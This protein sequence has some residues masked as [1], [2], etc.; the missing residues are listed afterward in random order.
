MVENSL[1][2]KLAGNEGAFDVSLVLA[3][4]SCMAYSVFSAS[5]AFVDQGNH[6]VPL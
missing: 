2:M 1:K 6:L 5:D 3:S 4:V